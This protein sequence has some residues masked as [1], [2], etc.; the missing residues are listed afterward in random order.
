MIDTFQ[1]ISD[2]F[3]NAHARNR[4][5]KL[6]NSH[7]MNEMSY[8][9]EF[10]DEI[11]KGR[12]MLLSKSTQKISSAILH[13]DAMQ[14]WCKDSFEDQEIGEYLKASKKIKGRLDIEVADGIFRA[15]NYERAM[16]IYDKMFVDEPFMHLQVIP[17][18]NFIYQ[19]SHITYFK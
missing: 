18:M 19:I 6:Q 8:E 15:G 12:E 4:V 17:K 3:F 10:E 11:Q 7:A 16:E 13:F 1:K 14:Y 9:F 2:T 5:N